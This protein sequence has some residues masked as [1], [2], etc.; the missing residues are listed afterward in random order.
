VQRAFWAVEVFSQTRE[1][2]VSARNT[3]KQSRD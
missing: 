3:M 1:S 2:R